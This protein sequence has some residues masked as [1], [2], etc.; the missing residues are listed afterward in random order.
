VWNRNEILISAHHVETKEERNIIVYIDAPNLEEKGTD[1]FSDAESDL[2]I[3]SEFC[4][5][6]GMLWLSVSTKELYVIDIEL[7]KFFVKKK[8]HTYGEISIDD[9][10]VLIAHGYETRV[11]NVHS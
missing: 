3:E 2:E 10:L 4:L 6:N 9:N 1:S 11:Y 8:I 7:M 5:L